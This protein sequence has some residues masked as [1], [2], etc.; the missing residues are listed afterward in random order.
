MTPES[1]KL[2]AE[3]HELHAGKLILTTSIHMFVDTVARRM[4]VQFLVVIVVVIVI[5][6]FDFIT[7]NDDVP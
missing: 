4:N 5:E 2:Y 7:L 6:Y 3:L 1:H